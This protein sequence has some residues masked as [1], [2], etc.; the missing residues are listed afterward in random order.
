MQKARVREGLTRAFRT[1]RVS[2]GVVTRRERV[3]WRRPHDFVAA[4]EALD[5][6]N[7]VI[8]RTP[9]Q[10]RSRRSEGQPTWI[11]PWRTANATASSFECTRS[12]PRMFRTC[13]CTVC[14]L[15]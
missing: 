15:M 5:T 4:P 8:A 10:E 6:R 11:A 7:G 9:S 3:L 2:E 12:L 14:G 1:G 13:V